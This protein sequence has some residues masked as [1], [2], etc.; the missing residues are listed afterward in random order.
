MA[1]ILT[2]I[3]FT[4]I[5]LKYLHQLQFSMY[6]ELSTLYLCKLTRKL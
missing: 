3:S 5:T 6:L 2:C 1:A 4:D